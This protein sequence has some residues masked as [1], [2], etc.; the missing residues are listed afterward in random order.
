MSRK[1]LKH[2]ITGGLLIIIGLIFLFDK[3]DWIQL[4]AVLPYWPFLF[5]IFGIKE[6]I[7]ATRPKNWIEG[8]WLV[9]IGLWL[10]VSLQKVF[11]LGF[12][13]TWPFILIFWGLTMIVKEIFPVFKTQPEKE[14]HY[15][16]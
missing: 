14:P 16:E 1:T 2:L 12:A 6:I 15:G 13:T 11:G 3:L 9:F 10:Y 8:S 5:V 7:F 4:K